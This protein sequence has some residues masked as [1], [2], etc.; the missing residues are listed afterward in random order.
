MSIFEYDEEKH[1]KSEREEWY[2]I[3][4]NDL[5]QLLRFLTE[6][7]KTDEVNSVLYDSE[8]RKEISKEY[9]QT[10]KYHA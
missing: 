10:P 6:A 9:F 5:A 4:S 7:G 3:G 1:M 8:Y 2:E